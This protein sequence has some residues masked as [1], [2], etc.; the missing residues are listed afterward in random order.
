VTDLTE[1]W[2]GTVEAPTRNQTENLLIERTR[3]V[4]VHQRA[5]GLD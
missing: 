3:N 4:D 5:T 1:R 2:S